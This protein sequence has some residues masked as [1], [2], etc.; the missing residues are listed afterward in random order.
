MGDRVS[1]HL[2]G[3][4]GVST[5]KFSWEKGYQQLFMGVQGTNNFSWWVDWGS[6]VPQI[7]AA[8]QN[9]EKVTGTTQ[10]PF[11]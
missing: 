1:H 4:G 10:I 2:I 3:L 9:S 6:F 11:C 7:C 8:T 5:N